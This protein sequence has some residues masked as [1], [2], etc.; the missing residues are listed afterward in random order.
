M[1]Q[2][3][4]HKRESYR[5]GETS[6]R[7]DLGLRGWVLA[8]LLALFVFAIP[9][10]AFALGPNA[11]IYPTGWNNN[12]VARGDDNT[13]P[14]VDLPF[15]MTWNGTTY[16]SVNINMNGN[17][18]FGTSFT[19][20]NP[21][22]L[23]SATG[24]NIMAPFWADVDTRNTSTGLCYYSD[25]ASSTAVTV[26]GHTAF[27]VTWQGV[28]RY[29][30]TT[31][32]LN[33][34]QLVIVDRT[35]VN[36]G[37]FDFW[38]NYDQ[39]LW[40][41]PTAASNS[42]PHAGWAFSDGSASYELAGGGTSGAMIDGGPNALIAGSLN[43]GGQLG[44]YVFEVR[45][46]ALAN[47]PPV[48][49]KSFNETDLE[50]NTGGATPGRS[51]YS[52]ATDA[53]AVDPDGT[54]VS[55]TRDPVAGTFLPMG[56]NVVTWTA[57]DNDGA[58]T[59][60]TQTINVVDT[61]PPTLPWAWSPTHTEGA[62]S[63]IG[64]MTA[65]WTSSTDSVS[66]VAG[67]SFDWTRDAPS[68]PDAVADAHTYTAGATT[69][70]VVENQDF[71]GATF[72]ADWT[73]AAANDGF[74]R[75]TATAGRYHLAARA[76][77]V[78]ASNNT[79][80]RDYFYK[81]Y[82]LRAFQ[83]ATLSWWDYHPVFNNAADLE[84]VS[85]STNGGTTWTNLYSATGNQAAWT[86]HS[87]AL[88]NLSSNY[89]VRFGAN[90]RANGHYVDWDE[91]GISAVAATP[92][93]TTAAPGD[94]SWYFNVRSGDT[95][96]NW[97]SPAESIGPFMI[98]SYPPITTSNIPVGWTNSITSVSLTATDAGSGVD[99]TRYRYDGGGWADYSAPF[100]AGV[101]G[102]HTL[103]FYSVDN[104]GHIETAH[105]ATLQLDTQAPSI[106]TSVTA[107]AV[108][109]TSVE[110]VWGSSIDTIS[111]VD[112]YEVY[113]DGSRVAT[114][115]LLLYTDTGI[116]PGTTHT[117]HIVAV[118]R[119]DNSSVDS[120]NAS[121]TTPEAAIWLSMS[122][123]AVDVGSINP[124]QASTVTSA[125]TVKVGGVGNLTYDFW[126][127]AADFDNADAMSQT[128]TMSVD[129]L[130]Y[131]TFGQVGIPLQQFTLAPYKINTSVGTKYVW[132]HDYRF[133]YV[134]TAPWTSEPGTYTTKV[135]Y[136]VVS[137]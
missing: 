4:L 40:D 65:V 6:P 28:A 134:L 124:G 72:P 104:V 69:V 7:A 121:A 95:L 59:V 41:Y 5:S 119:A 51:G 42:Y 130:S 57:T 20:Y 17:A 11:M 36:P 13:F 110:V 53:T 19:E 122:T 64:T 105:T 9:A 86:Q 90:V 33:Y 82:D 8:G 10:K 78:Y 77:E 89:M 132:Q 123:D 137:H 94:G 37:D 73:Q 32:P 84:T 31:S 12:S 63:S 61:T 83:S 1:T 23:L 128:P 68:L 79:T 55:F 3:H 112:Y 127:S 54:V 117:Y 88:P 125:T 108:G 39:M 85:Y 91:I 29:N 22:R 24:R 45:S 44:R 58:V 103:D 21:N 34:F 52:G 126:C 25:A 109:T 111:G 14:T 101:D 129:A 70:V 93:S 100:A 106:P 115:A 46:G 133:D 87:V 66:T 60:A 75:L 80:R 71:A 107:S 118:D 136:T 48:I 67:Y 38:F 99:Y 18:T 81:T 35:D 50:A 114:T 62:W 74:L 30:N 120:A 26:D 16:S 56:S 131:A 92:N 49:T 76:A 98:E 135:L 116:T 43:S 2:M 96:G 113:R 102:T 15:N 27:V 47:E 97:N